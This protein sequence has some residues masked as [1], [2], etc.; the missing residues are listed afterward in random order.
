LKTLLLIGGTGFFGNS[1]LKYFSN[2]KFLKKKFNKIIIISRNKL[3]KFEYIKQLKKNYKLEK[4][5]SDIF[6]LKKLPAADYVIYAVIIKNFRKDYLA[7]KNYTRLALKYHK[8]SKILFSSSGA[9]YGVQPNNLKSFKEDY[10]KYNKKIHFKKSYK[11]NY[12]NFKLKSEKLFQEL[13][14]Y[15]LKVSIARCF[16]FVGEFLPL[17]SNFVIGNIIKNVL[18]EKIITINA[19]YKIY[20]SYMYS[21]D[22]VKWLFKIL[23]HADMKC[24]IYNVGSNNT[25]SIQKI[26][27]TLGKTYNLRVNIPQINNKISDYY[28]PNVNK[29]KKNIKLKNNYSSLQ[30]IKK[31]IQLILKKNRNEKK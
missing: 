31:T 20:R 22:L 8:N 1:I 26:L 2:S 27:K 16:A 12:S 23:G 14:N 11:K 17:N 10:L 25:I 19:K 4:I 29:A 18:D 9:I 30:A 28:I 3:E 7:V 13:G 15:G 24:P 21:D 5:N 6:K